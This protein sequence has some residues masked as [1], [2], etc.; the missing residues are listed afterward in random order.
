MITQRSHHVQLHQEEKEEPI[1]DVDDKVPLALR[2][3]SPS[4]KHYLLYYPNFVN[5]G[6]VHL[7]DV[8]I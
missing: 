2:D 6:S 5:E 1:P 3:F 8:S 4:N 7:K